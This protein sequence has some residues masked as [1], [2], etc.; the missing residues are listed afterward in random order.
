MSKAPKIHNADSAIAAKV[1]MRRNVL[2]A[3]T[4][5]KSIVFDAFSGPG[6]MYNA[7]WNE[8]AG[9]VGCDE[10]WFNDDRTCYAADNR[11]VMRC[12]DLQP[13]TVFDLDAFGSP[14]DQVTILA[15]RRRLRPG[16]RVGVLLTQGDTKTTRYRG[17]NA[18]LQLAGIRIPLGNERRYW[19]AAARA[20]EHM[21]RQMGGRIVKHWKAD[22]VSQLIVRYTAL[23]IDAN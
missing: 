15:A 18:M 20:Y 8:A 9:Y 3:L 17:S 23:V 11:R 12:I 1:E 22:G 21:A 6:E 5:E 14:W 16:E 19:E 2:N 10:Q 4:P 7:V 13:F